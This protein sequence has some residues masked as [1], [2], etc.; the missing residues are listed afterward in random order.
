MVKNPGL[1]TI[2]QTLRN[3]I[4]SKFQHEID[5]GKTIR[6]KDLYI[7]FSHFLHLDKAATKMLLIELGFTL[8]NH[9]YVAPESLKKAVRGFSE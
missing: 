2:E 6:P 5:T 8:R 9:G 3:K 7:F 1:N 4:N